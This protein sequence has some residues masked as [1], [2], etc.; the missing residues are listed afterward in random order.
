MPSTKLY[1]DKR[2]KRAQVFPVC[3]SVS[4]NCKTI[5]IP[6]GVRVAADEWRN[7]QVTNRT[8]KARLNA[9]IRS[10]RANVDSL[11]LGLCQG[12]KIKHMTPAEIKA[13]ILD[14][15]NPERAA[16]RITFK[17]AADKFVGTRI[18]RTRELYI[19]TLRKVEQF[20]DNYEY[21][22]FAEI[23][24]AWLDD[25]TAYYAEQGQAV[26]TIAI[27]LR[28]IR[29]V[30]NYARKVGLTKEYPFLNYKIK[31]EQTRH[32][33]TQPEMIC[34]L[35]CWP[36][37]PEQEKYRDIYL[38]IFYL[39]GINIKDLCLA[40]PD[41]IVNGRLEYRRAK[42][43]K[44]YSVKITPQAREILDRYRGEEYLL[45]V[46]DGRKDYKS[47]AKALN[48]NIQRIGY[49]KIVGRGGKKEITPIL[50]GNTTYWMR[51]SWA[52]IAHRIGVQKDTISMA[53]GHSFG[54]GVT[55]TYINYDAEQVDAANEKVLAFLDNMQ[56]SN[57]FKE[58]LCNMLC[59]SAVM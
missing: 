25:F 29:A 14:G 24:P 45:S 49:C 47:F 33:D 16:A 58:L 8:D 41:S 30:F 17:H 26:N 42:T 18:A 40:R 13:A 56:E 20:A 22:S 52:T 2:N 31:R 53:L 48:E 43:H 6:T 38:L 54:A 36:V 32:R 10:Y 19:N 57:E 11:L 37:T 46:M 28:N 39:L 9:V 12:S 50:P 15:L 23:S 27:D 21:L 7:E 35:R 59:L 3:I 34:A 4:A 51:H 1:L 55:D 5:L 44:L